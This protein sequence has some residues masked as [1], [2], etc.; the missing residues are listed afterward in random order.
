[1]LVIRP[2]QCGK[3]VQWRKTIPHILQLQEHTQRPLITIFMMDH[4]NENYCEALQKLK[5][6]E[7]Q[8][9]LLPFLNKLQ[10]ILNMR[11]LFKSIFG[12]ILMLLH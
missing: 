7:K 8:T 2:E 10:E 1:M 12:H 5:S 6:V 9:V 11:P 3:K 4:A